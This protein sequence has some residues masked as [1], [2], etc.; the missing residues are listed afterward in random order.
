[1]GRQETKLLTEEEKSINLVDIF[2]Y[3][4]SYWK[5]YV[6]SILI[7][8]GYFWYDYSKTPFIYGRSATV[9]IKTPANSPSTIRLRTAITV[10]QDKSTW[11]MNCCSSGRKN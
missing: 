11:R 1:M 3:L 5:W 7:F 6:L 9:M 4:L 2:M 10:G 8:G